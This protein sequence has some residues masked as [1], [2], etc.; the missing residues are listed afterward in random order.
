M[1]CARILAAVVLFALVAAACESDTP[2]TLPRDS[3]ASRTSAPAEPASP[4]S[5]ASPDGDSPF[6]PYPTPR[7]AGPEQ[8][9]AAKRAITHV[10]FLI[11]ENRTF[12]TYFG[13]FPGA[14]GA[15]TGR[16]C[17]GGTVPLV[18]AHDVTS[19]PNHSFEGGIRAINGG[20]MNCFDE[21][22]YGLMLQSYVQ[23]TQKQIPNYW[24]YAKRF[25]LA[26]RF[27][28]GVYGPTGVE[29]L[30][31][32]AA[33][34]D[35]FI[36]H[37]RANPPGQFGTNGIPREF[38][39]D[40]TERAYSLKK[41]RPRQIDRAGE[42]QNEGAGGRFMRKFTYLRRAC[43]NIQILPDELEA[44][45]IPWAYYLGDNDYVETP[46]WIRHWAFG[47]M[48]KNVKTDERFLLARPTASVPVRTGP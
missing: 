18:K 23:Y 37:E 12:D 28:T 4:T 20:A 17:D 34:T 5:S 2:R 26:D 30:D 41:L 15:T 16:T 31:S 3:A 10:V 6:D 7:L 44:A 25:V 29:H 27:F 39:H 11:K 47:P 38:C 19:G 9:A 48:M 33:Q 22:D 21:L 45:D 43:T 13:R 46:S 8:I 24:A 40:D 14:N 1:S 36:D 42:V 32:V 35:R